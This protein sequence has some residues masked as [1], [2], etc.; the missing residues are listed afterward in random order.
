M[1]SIKLFMHYMLCLKKSSMSFISRTATLMCYGQTGA[2]KTF[3]ITGATE[4]YQHRGMIPRALSQLFSDIEDRPEYSIAVRLAKFYLSYPFA[5]RIA[6]TLTNT[7]CVA[8][9]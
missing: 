3:T 9:A 8:M 2:G 4:S 7:V 1:S 5:V 6:S